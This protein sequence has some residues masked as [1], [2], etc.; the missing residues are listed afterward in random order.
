VS[1]R[2]SRRTG[3]VGAIIGLALGA[4]YLSLLAYQRIDG[5]LFP[6]NELAVPSVSVSIPATDIG[7]DVSLPGVSTT[8]REPWTPEDRRNILVLGLDRRPGEPEDASYRA[9][10][11]F[12]ASIDKH[13]G[14][15]QLLAIPRDTLADIP[16]GDTIGVWAQNKINAAYSYGQ[17]YKYPG[18][19]AAACVAAV[20]KN[21]SID[22]HQ[23]VVIDWVGFVE[24]IDAIGGI[25]IDVPAEISDFGTDVLDSFPDQTVKAGQQHMDGAQAL[26][27]SRVRVDGDLKRIERQQIVIQ[28]V[29]NKSVSLGLVAKVP[30]MWDAYHHAIRTDIETAQIPGF[31]LLAKQMDLTRIETFSLGPA[32]Y[33][34]IAEDG[35]LVLLQNQDKVYDIIDRFLAD[36]ETLDEAPK[37]VL[38]YG[39]GQEALAKAA[40]AHAEAYGLPPAFLTLQKS[41]AAGTPGIFDLTGKAYTAGKLHDLFDLQL[42]NPSGELPDGADVV[43]RIGAETALKTP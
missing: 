8:A 1:L 20:E 36:P 27:Y 5:Y 24:V 10:T 19:G 26:G 31:A 12:V 42:L 33:G 11:M 6:G 38:Q 41:E 43:V 29:A 32:M 17:F 15:L 40:L 21:F 23:V 14:R 3:W 2:I 34:G 25:D 22:I 7:V 35:Q 39:A 30:E 37:V 28:S 4:V 13:A 18:G 9:D 16:Y